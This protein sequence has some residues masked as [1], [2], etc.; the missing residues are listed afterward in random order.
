[1]RRTD[2]WCDATSER[3][4]I[5]FK[6]F[7]ILLTHSGEPFVQPPASIQVKQ[8]YGNMRHFLIKSLASYG[9]LHV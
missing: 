7:A 8:V 4:A 5:D 3:P 6:G 1:M 9:R 2:R